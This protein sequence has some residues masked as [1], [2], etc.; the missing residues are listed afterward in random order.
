MDQLKRLRTE[1]GLSQAKLAA[2]A[3]IDPSTVN[4]IERGA[5]EA[6]P[7]TLRKLAQAL[8]VSLAE[9]L[10][11]ATPK[12]PAP[13]SL[14][15]NG[16]TDEERRSKVEVVESYMRYA[17]SRAEYYERELERSRTD[18]YATA[19]GAI[20]LAQLALAEFISFADWLFSGPAWELLGA[21]LEQ[22]GS[23]YLGDFEATMDAMVTRQNQ[24]LRT[25]FDNAEQLAET[26][27]QKDAL[28][29]KRQQAAELN[30]RME[31]LSA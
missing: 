9:L 24:T 11:D 13:P 30:A 15:N 27:Q 16:I 22:P 21:L 31:R 14:F 6:S 5:R 26:E 23:G 10:E 2:L 20:T 4:Q 25:L 29:A 19:S 18:Q 1:K 28:A 7:A 3:D 8:D 17:I 12:A